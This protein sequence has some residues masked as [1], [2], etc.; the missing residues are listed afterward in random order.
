[1]SG[2]L[3]ETKRERHARF[4]AGQGPCLLL[5]P[6]DL[7]T[8]A[9]YDMT[10][11][12]ARFENPRLMWESEI[13][14][15][16]LQIDWPTDGIPTV[17]PNLGTVFVPALAGQEVLVS[18]QAMPWHGAELTHEQVRAARGV[19]V[20][21][22]S[23]MRRALEF[24]AL[25]AAAGENEIAPYHPDTQGVFDIAH[26]LTGNEIFVDLFAGK[27]DPWLRDCMEIA[28]EL[29]LNATRCVKAAMGE[30]NTS[31]IHGHG[32]PQ[33]I[34]FPHA[35]TR[36]SE[37]TLVLL[38]LATTRE[39]IEPYLVASMEA[40]GGAF[41]H[42]CGHRPDLFT[43]FCDQPLVRA[44]DL[45][46]P[47]MYDTRWLLSECARAGK[48]LFSR[49]AAEPDERPLD[50]IRRIAGLVRETGARCI[51]R[52][53]LQPADRAEA[54]AMLE[55]WHALTDAGVAAATA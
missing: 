9:I 27:D 6:A 41:V 22:Q 38:K 46:N 48:V 20:A 37:D 35:G 5:T 25:H 31:M 16:R 51:L 34:Y 42:Y 44:I 2:S 23:L 13:A 17:R 49:I 28:L 52:S 3:L 19:D 32:T 50:Y 53:T 7:N 29:F 21:E 26:L 12:P 11:Y 33:G 54:Q 43:F 24:Y 30:S 18:D 15:A 40:F 39:I 55:L 45:G 1:M 10:N 14:R 4:W 36:I 8:S 47:E